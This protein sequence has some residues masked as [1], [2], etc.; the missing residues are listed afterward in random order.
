MK[1]LITILIL[2]SFACN[3]QV[4][5]VTPV[6]QLAEEKGLL[7]PEL[8]FN[9][10]ARFT[11]TEIAALRGKPSRGKDADKDGVL[12][13]V[14]NCK[15]TY[16]PF[17]EDADGDGIGDACDLW[18]DS[19]NDGVQD[20]DDNCPSTPNANQLDCNRN[21]IGDVC[22]HSP[23]TTTEA[24]YV[25]FL[26][27]DGHY[28][29]ENYWTA[30]NGGQP[31]HALNSGLSETEIAQVVEGVKADYSMFKLT[32]TTDST[33]FHNAQTAKRQRVIITQSNEWY[34]QAGGV[35]YVGSMFFTS[36]QPA[37]VFSKLLYYYPFYIAGCASHEAGHTM[38][39]Y[40]QVD[41]DINTCIY[42]SSY[43]AGFIMGNPY[44]SVQQG[45]KW[46]EGPAGVYVTNGFYCN[47][48]GK[49]ND[50]AQIA[51]KVTYK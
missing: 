42:N 33:V 28:V 12:D 1:Y 16:N 43:R 45:R 17:Q 14:D 51:Q 46:T 27:F 5:E 4:Q 10:V 38:G 25:L 2:F 26:D 35:A 39:L 8:K 49:Q 9:A 7:T 32:I 31:F 6:A 22:D 34:G 29:T 23:C 37:F 3:K 40:H 24:E 36:N 15:F 44:Y 13:A 19:D 41:L 21:G 30:N 11:N 48:Y 20:K 50:T 18:T 47:Q